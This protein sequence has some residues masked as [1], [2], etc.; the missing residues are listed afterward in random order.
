MGHASI[1]T[2]IDTYGHL[3]SNKHREM[4]DKLDSL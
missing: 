1:T 4:S 3:S 2:A